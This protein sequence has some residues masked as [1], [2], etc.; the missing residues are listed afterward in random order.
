MKGF[1]KQFL[2]LREV[3]PKLT[4]AVSEKDKSYTISGDL[5][6]FDAK[7]RYLD[8]FS[9]LVIINNSF[10][11]SVPQVIEVSH[12]I[13]R[14]DSR[15]I[16]KDGVCCLEMD[17]VLLAEAKKGIELKKYFINRVY[18]YFANQV[19]YCRTGKYANG[20]WDHY[21][22]GVIQYYSEVLC[23]NDYSLIIRFLEGIIGRCLPSRNDLCFCEST[24]YKKC[25]HSKSVDILSLVPLNRLIEDLK[26]FRN[27]AK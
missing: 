5:D 21:F 22:K 15:H 4:S 25:Y 24:K 19:Y 17:H 23:M 3:F 20:E 13:P 7:E 2:E 8:T 26:G 9:I 11:K 16:S 1:E 14:N 18:P 10:P 27:I 12:K 6:I